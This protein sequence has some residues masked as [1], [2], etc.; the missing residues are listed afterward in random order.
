MTTGTTSR[1]LMKMR[2]PINNRIT[3]QPCKVLNNNQRKRPQR[4]LEEAKQNIESSQ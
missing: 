2:L 3:T 1:H 4:N